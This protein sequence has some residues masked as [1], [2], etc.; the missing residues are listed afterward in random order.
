[1]L[2]AMLPCPV[3]QGLWVIHQQQTTLLYEE[4]ARLREDRTDPNSETNP[5]YCHSIA[6]AIP[7]Y[8]NMASPFYF[9][10]QHNTH[11][12][13]EVLTAVTAE[14][15]IFWHKMMSCD[16]ENYRDF[17]WT[18]C[19]HLCQISTRLHDIISQNMLI[20]INTRLSFW[21]VCWYLE[22]KN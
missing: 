14:A 3:C 10:W 2:R 16:V 11:V 21:Q 15:T 18:Y 7:S 4:K 19:L 1:M 17:R 6:R 13:F 12:R 20:L 8:W 9:H 5:E 22:K